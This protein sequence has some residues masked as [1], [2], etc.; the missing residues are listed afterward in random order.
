MPKFGTAA[1]AWFATTASLIVF[2][3]NEAAEENKMKVK[4]LFGIFVFIMT[5]AAASAQYTGTTRFAAKTDA[6]NHAGYGESEI[7]VKCTP[8]LSAVVL[9]K[10]EIYSY[11]V[12]VNGK[13]SAQVVPFEEERLVVK[14]GSVLVEVVLYKYDKRGNWKQNGSSRRNKASLTCDADSNLNMLVI[15]ENTI[16]MAYPRL[17]NINTEPLAGK[18]YIGIISFGPNANDLT[19]G[20]PI[21]LNRGGYNRILSILDKD[22]KKTPQQGTSLYY[23]VHKALAN[24]TANELKFPKDLVAVNLLTFTDGIDNN[25]TSLGCGR[26]KRAWRV[27][28]SQTALPLSWKPSGLKTKT[29]ASP[30]WSPRPPSV[31]PPPSKIS[32]GRVNSEAQV[33]NRYR[34]VM[35]KIA[36]FPLSILDD[37]GL[38]RFTLEETQELLELFEQRYDRA[39]TLICAQMPPSGWHELFPDPTLA[40]AILDRVIHKAQRY[41]ID[42]ESMR[43]VLVEREAVARQ[44]GPAPLAQEPL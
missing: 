13:L 24:L 33:E 34:S 32:N 28:P 41:A 21:Y 40:D 1:L 20:S 27:S 36:S 38:R 4:S 8:E 42:G 30:G 25:S 14:N 11:A 12:F 2:R 7:L 43:K 31:S 35:K 10:S 37:W 5:A 29:A 44:E 15:S 39:S 16:G 17:T 19:G 6:G 9:G 22:Y 18:A 3:Y 23:A 26:K